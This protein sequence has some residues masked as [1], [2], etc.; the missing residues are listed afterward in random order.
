MKNK[1]ILNIKT[2][3]IK[4][5]CWVFLF[6]PIFLRLWVLLGWFFNKLKAI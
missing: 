5:V 4:F 2:F 1:A 6:F 3:I